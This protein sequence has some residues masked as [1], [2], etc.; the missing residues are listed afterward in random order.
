MKHRILGNIVLIAVLLVRLFLYFICHSAIDTMFSIGSD[1]PWYV[2]FALRLVRYLPFIVV[3]LPII[4]NLLPVPAD[5]FLNDFS[6]LLCIITGMI[7]FAFIRYG[8]WIGGPSG[9]EMPILDVVVAIVCLVSIVN[10]SKIRNTG[11]FY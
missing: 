2:S 5:I 1:V 7:E 3:I 4:A 11:E 6:I 8:K 9:A 10:S